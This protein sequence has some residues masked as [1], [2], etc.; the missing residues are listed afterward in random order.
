MLRRNAHDRIRLCTGTVAVLVAAVVQL[1][2]VLFSYSFR[3][4]LPIQLGHQASSKT[5]APSRSVRA[6]TDEGPWVSG[7]FPVSHRGS[8]LNSGGYQLMRPVPTKLEDIRWGPTERAPKPMGYAAGEGRSRGETHPPKVPDPHQN[9]NPRRSRIGA[10]RL[11]RRRATCPG[12]PKNLGNSKYQLRQQP[13][14]VSRIPSN[15]G[16]CPCGSRVGRSDEP[17]ARAAW[18]S[19]R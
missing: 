8:Q 19:R 11:P 15:P 18:P 10:S 13:P 17:P 5:R 9:R 14:R 4:S 3:G 12:I 16:R 6:I 2:K 7:A 1:E